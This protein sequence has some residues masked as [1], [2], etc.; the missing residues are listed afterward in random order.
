VASRAASL[1][2]PAALRAA[3]LALSIFPSA[4]ILVSPVIFPAVSL[5]APFALSAGAFQMLT[6][7]FQISVG[8]SMGKRSSSPHVP[9]VFQVGRVPDL[10]AAPKGPT[11]RHA[12]RSQMV[13]PTT[14]SQSASRLCL[15]LLASVTILSAMACLTSSAQSPTC[16]A[17]AMMVGSCR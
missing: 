17:R 5:I 7:H 13:S 10:R 14:R 15:P 12:Q 11:A 16:R 1:T 6:I 8:D 3:P 4:C 2:S 9:I